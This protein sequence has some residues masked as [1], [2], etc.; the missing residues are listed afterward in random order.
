MEVM[1]KSLGEERQQT[2]SIFLPIS[3]DG[4]R[5]LRADQACRCEGRDRHLRGRGRG[6]NGPSPSPAAMCKLQWKPDFGAR[7][8]ALGVDFEMYGKD[9]STNTP[10][11]DAICEILGAPA[12]EHFTYELFL[13]ENGQKISKSKGNGISID[14]WLRYAATESL[15][16]SCT[17]SPRRRSGSIST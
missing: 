14:E 9:H 6:A 16:I 13:D 4:P 1:L 17:R 8:A 11:Y 2:Y 10:I 15:P 5:A 12:P 7:W 3:R